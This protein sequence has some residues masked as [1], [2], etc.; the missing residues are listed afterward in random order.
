MRLQIHAVSFAEDGSYFVTA[1][2]KHIK[3]WYL[4]P[5]LGLKSSAVRTWYI[6]HFYYLRLI[7]L[8]KGAKAKLVE[9]KSAILG[10]HKDRYNRKRL[11]LIT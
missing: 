1:G 8:Q 10:S 9:S 11:Y 7:V 5:Q 3:F 2:N 6:W 4:D